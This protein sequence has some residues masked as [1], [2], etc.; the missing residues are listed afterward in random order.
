MLLVAKAV[1]TRHVTSVHNDMPGQEPTSAN[2]APKTGGTRGSSGA[3]LAARVCDAG[4]VSS[5]CESVETELA[6]TAR[7]QIDASAHL[8]TAAAQTPCVRRD[9]RCLSRRRFL[10]KVTVLLNALQMVILRCDRSLSSPTQLF[11]IGTA[12]APPNRVDRAAY[13]RSGHGHPLGRRGS[14]R[15]RRT[16]RWAAVPRFS[17]G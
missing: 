4:A 9:S 15:Q 3:R 10:G 11:S 8:F 2:I 16:K 6:S 7:V 17:S 12:F 1:P 5:W 14:R 13:C